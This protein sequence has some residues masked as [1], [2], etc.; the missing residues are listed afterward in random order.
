MIEMLLFDDVINICKHSVLID[1]DHER[2]FSKYLIS[3][4]LFLVKK[5]MKSGSNG[6]TQTP[7]KTSDDQKNME[8]FMTKIQ[9]IFVKS[10]E[11]YE[12]IAPYLGE[13]YNKCDESYKKAK[14]YINKYW[15][16]GLTEIFL[17]VVLLFFGGNFAMTIACYVAVQLTGLDKIK[18]SIRVL[19]LNYSEALKAALKDK[20]TKK[21]FDKDGD[22]RISISESLSVFVTFIKADVTTKKTML[23]TMRG[24]LVAVEPQQVMIY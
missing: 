11:F 9:P 2:L 21:L 17:G 7:S 14:P 13:F 18:E 19:K 10:F 5:I 6:T 24:V 3:L 16:E 4:T 1:T 23:Y 12:K 8:S 15:F 20:D 22:G